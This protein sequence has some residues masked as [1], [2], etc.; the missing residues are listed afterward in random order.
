MKIGQKSKT[1]EALKKVLH[2]LVSVA[3]YHQR[4]PLEKEKDYRGI[5]RHLSKASPKKSMR[6]EYLS[7]TRSIDTKT[8]GLKK[9]NSA[10][11][12]RNCF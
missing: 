1:S 5:V 2:T 3:S 7:I 10:R 9:S 6:V 4:P 8:R 12:C 11:P